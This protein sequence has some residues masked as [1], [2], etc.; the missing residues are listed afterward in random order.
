ML[1]DFFFKSWVLGGN[2]KKIKKCEQGGWGLY[3]VDLFVDLNQQII[4]TIDQRLLI[5]GDL[6]LNNGHGLGLTNQK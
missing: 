3:F 2:T 4:R 5:A 1:M 6:P